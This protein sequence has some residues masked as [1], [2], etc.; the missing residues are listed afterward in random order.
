MLN[1]KSSSILEELGQ[2][3]LQL[4]RRLS[5]WSMMT[6]RWITGPVFQLPRLL[7]R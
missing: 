5:A 1:A 2:T 3:T 6:N 7:R 4:E